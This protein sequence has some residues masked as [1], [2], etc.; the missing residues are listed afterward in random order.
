[1]QKTEDGEL[2]LWKRGAIHYALRHVNLILGVEKTCDF[3]QNCFPSQAEKGGDCR[4]RNVG[5]SITCQSYKAS[6][7]VETSRSMHCRGE[8]HRRALNNKKKDSMLWTHCE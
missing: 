8:E 5:Y 4:K 1:M 6:Y 7:H 3:R 2:R